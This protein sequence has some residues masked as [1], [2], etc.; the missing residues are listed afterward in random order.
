VVVPHRQA[1][2]TIVGVSRSAD[3]S[4]VVRARARVTQA[5]NLSLGEV[6]SVQIQSP[7]SAVQGW[8]V[9]I[10]AVVQHPTTPLVFVMTDKGFRPTAVRVLSS[11]DD[12]AIVDGPLQAQSRVAI[13]GV[14]SL[15]ALQQQE[16]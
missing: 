8:R 13:T 14:A 16:P 9:P 10:Q 5:G 2:A 4:Q 15:R 6:V 1:K 3:A 12:R 11:N 7:M